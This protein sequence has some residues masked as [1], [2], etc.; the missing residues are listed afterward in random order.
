MNRPVWVCEL[1]ERFWAAAGSPPPFP[2]DLEAAAANA[3]PLS[4]IDRPHLRLSTVVEYLNRLRSPLALAEPDRPLRAALYC[5]K[6]TGFLFLDTTDPPDERRFSLAHEVA[7]FLRDY[8]ALRRQVTKSL[9]SDALAVLDGLRPAT[10]D[11]RLS[12]VLRNRPLTPHAHFMNR[13][14]TG[15]PKGDDE[16]RAEAD[17]D[18]LAFELLAPAELLT[19]ETDLPALATRLIAEFGLPP[20]AALAYSSLLLPSPPPVGTMVERIRKFV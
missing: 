18:R 15:R 11:E 2:R 1:T 12:A 10:A 6:G 14:A 13:D 8:D 17:A 4:V 3:A 5:W 20:S 7:H 9:G 16:R 19:G